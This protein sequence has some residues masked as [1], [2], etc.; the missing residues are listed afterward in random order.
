M[1]HIFNHSKPSDMYMN[2]V[3]YDWEILHSSHNISVCSVW[4]WQPIPII[5]LNSIEWLDCIMEMDCHLYQMGDEVLC[6]SNLDQSTSS[7]G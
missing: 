5:S 2:H 1:A 3:L 6:S 4:L 7:E